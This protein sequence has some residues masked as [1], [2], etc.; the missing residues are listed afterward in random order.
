MLK[1]HNL[2][3]AF[4]DASYIDLLHL[5]TVHLPFSIKPEAE[6]EEGFLR[7]VATKVYGQ[8]K[9]LHGTT[10]ANFL[11]KERSIK[12]YHHELEHGNSVIKKKKR[13]AKR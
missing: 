4:A 12:V 9:G 1:W 2:K 13:A 5:S 11:E 6:R 10:R 3:N 8:G 7:A